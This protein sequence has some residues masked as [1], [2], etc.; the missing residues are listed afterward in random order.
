MKKPEKK[1]YKKILYLLKEHVE[2]NIKEYLIISIIFLIGI[3]LGVIFINNINNLQE[4]QINNYINNF[5]EALK[6]D[7]KI[8]TNALL[9]KTII[10]NIILVIG[11][12][13]ISMIAVIG[14]PIVCAIV[15]IRGFMLGYTISASIVSLGIWKG[16]LFNLSSLF[17]QNV[18]FI[19][20]IIALGVSGVKLYKSIVNNKKRENVK[21]E[22]IR[23][24]IFSGIIGSILILSSF[25]E[26]YISGNLLGLF[27]NYI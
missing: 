13:L 15:L 16:I 27:V 1:I 14:I 2:N 3:V 21:I 20:C 26:T 11:I 4:E 24:T 9:H 7:Y 23:H 17:F 5:I 18:I 19:P 25:I 10:S 8:D 12:W 22:I 6:T